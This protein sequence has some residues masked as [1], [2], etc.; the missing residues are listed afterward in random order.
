MAAM[1]GSRRRRTADLHTPVG[2]ENVH[3]FM[4]GDL[5]WFV[6]AVGE[7]PEE[8]EDAVPL[9]ENARTLAEL[10]GVG[11]KPTIRI[12]EPATQSLC[13]QWSRLHP[14]ICRGER[15]WYF[16]ERGIGAGGVRK[17]RRILAELQQARPGP[18]V[19]AINCE[20]SRLVSWSDLEQL[21]KADVE[22]LRQLEPISEAKLAEV[23]AAAVENG[24]TIGE[25]R[26]KRQ[27]IGEL[28]EERK[29][30]ESKEGCRSPKKAARM[31]KK[32]GTPGC[33]F[34]DHHSGVCSL[35]LDLPPRRRTQVLK[36]EGTS[37]KISVG[38]QQQATVRLRRQA[39]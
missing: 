38:S 11:S 27:R 12:D 7:E 39:M 4:V 23:L 28:R 3:N 13:T 9:A 15:C 8:D 19:R 6:G 29:G 20:D 36:T 2:G 37:S 1:A 35:D 18:S 25:V 24:C 21:S 31:S 10:L 5:C 17:S 30:K 26:W 32:C 16:V 33:T 22:S 14:L 34:L